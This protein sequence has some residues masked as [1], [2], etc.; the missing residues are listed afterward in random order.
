M[1][2]ETTFTAKEIAEIL[3]L[4][5]QAII[6]RAKKENWV[7]IV[8]NGNGGKTRKY[9]LSALPADIQEAI[10]TA[11]NN[12]DTNPGA[13]LEIMNMLPAL[14]PSAAALIINKYN[15]VTDVIN[16]SMTL[17]LTPVSQGGLDLLNT[18]RTPETAIREQDMTDPRIA[19][20]LAI[21][22]EVDDMPRSWTG[23]KRKWIE[24]VA[25]RHEIGWQTVYKWLKKYEEKGIP[26]LRHTKSYADAPRKWSPDAI[27]FWVSLCGKREHRAANRKDLYENCLI[28]E[29]HRRGWHIGGYESANWWF[30]KKWNPALDALQRGGMRALDN[31]L[32]PILRDYSDLAPFQIIVGDQHRFDRWVMDE[33]TGEIFRPEGYLWQ[34]LRSRTIYGAAVDKKYDAWLIGLALR[35]GVSCY[36]AFHSIYTDNGKPEL[37]RFLTSILANLNSHGIKWEKTDEL[38][39]DLLDVDAEDISPCCLMPGSH[40]KAIVKNAKAKMIEGTFDRLEEIMASVMMLPGHTKKMSDDIHWQDID[41][42]EAQKLA[43]QGKLLTS[44]EFALAMYRACDYYNNK[45]VHRGVLAEWSWLPKPKAVTPL[46]CLHACYK[47]GWRPKMLSNDAADLLFLARDTRIINKGQIS[48][49]NEFYVHDALIELHKQRVDIRFN[50]MTYEKVHIYQGGKYICTAYP[51]ERSSMIDDDLASQKIAEKRERRRKFAEEFKKISSIA[52]DFRQYSTVPE[53]ER[54]AALIGAEKKQRA[55]ENK[56]MT[57]QI[58]QEELDRGVQALEVLNRVPAK[59]NKPLAPPRPAYWTSDAARHDYCILAAVDGS[60]S[61]E[62]LAWMKNY[63]AAMTPEARERWEF[64]REYRAEAQAQ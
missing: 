58:T 27:D 25:M 16:T 29:A 43:A 56:E 12:K 47:D 33:E 23:G 55:I 26:G 34:D 39:T 49:A 24:S 44:R 51:V 22:R 54:V 1:G 17:A 57:K 42:Q 9:P 64:E 18:E 59:T 37:S 61:E 60:I 21:L 46:D 2:N 28:I 63:E 10:I 20:I 13:S 6:A 8:E 35:I 3:G 4:T 15:D 19:K 40:R 38:V 5:K 36:G 48:L 45:K 50:P 41:H 7:C 31:I 32:P 52:P 62:D 53:G 14:K 11:H 30:D